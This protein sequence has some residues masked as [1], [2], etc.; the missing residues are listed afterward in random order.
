MKSCEVGEQTLLFPLYRKETEG[1]RVSDLYKI[2]SK[3]KTRV[4]CVCGGVV[5]WKFV[6]RCHDFKV[7]AFWAV[8]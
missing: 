8:L 1:Q 3:H 2:Q 7:R 6:S 5:E 4:V